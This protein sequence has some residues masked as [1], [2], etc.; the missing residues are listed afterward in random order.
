MAQIYSLSKST[1]GWQTGIIPSIGAYRDKVVHR[2]CYQKKSQMKRTIIPPI[3]R[4]PQ[5]QSQSH[6]AFPSPSTILSFDRTATC[7]VSWVISLRRFGVLGKL[8]ATTAEELGCTW[9]ITCGGIPCGGISSR[10]VLIGATPGLCMSAML[11]KFIWGLGP[12]D[13]WN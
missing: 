8:E 7:L 10:S 1:L 9:S 4:L 13:L 12:R 2:L 3:A 5:K 11:A 6:D